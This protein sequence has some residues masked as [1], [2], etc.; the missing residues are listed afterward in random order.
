[1]STQKKAPVITTPKGLAEYPWLNE[2]DTKFQAEGTYKVNLV[3]DDT[4]AT[5]NLLAR[6]E[7]IRDD[8]VEEWSEDP[9]N[10]KVKNP[11]LADIYEENEDGTITLKFK[12]KAQIKTREGQVVDVNIPLFDSKG[13][14]MNERIGRGS[15]IKVSFQTVPY[16][17]ASSKSIGVSLR[18]K[19]VQVIDLKSAM[20]GSDASSYGFEEEDGYTTEDIPQTSPGADPFPSEDNEE[21]L[22][23]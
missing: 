23:F 6:L 4:P 13:K 1:M 2:P 20:G 18:I 11:H 19:A 12:A 9:R 17:M 16:Y 7:Q 22:P 15:T 3:L 5:R 14:P 8:F 10:S 21:D